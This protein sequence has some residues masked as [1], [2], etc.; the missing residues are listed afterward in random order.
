LPHSKVNKVWSPISRT[1][2]EAIVNMLLEQVQLI[3]KWLCVLNLIGCLL[4]DLPTVDGGE[5]AKNGTLPVP[6]DS[7][8]WL[9]LTKS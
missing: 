7:V 8:A 4:P 9:P 5:F 6:F 2:L 3:N 1:E